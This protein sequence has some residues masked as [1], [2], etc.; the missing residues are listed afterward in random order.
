MGDTGADQIMNNLYA[1]PVSHCGMIT[2]S[3]V[4]SLK[5]AHRRGHLGPAGSLV[6][7]TATDHPR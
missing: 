2:T 6:S 3:F 5:S 7:A 4:A 1:P